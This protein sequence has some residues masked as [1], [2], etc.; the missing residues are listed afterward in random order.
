VFPVTEA[1]A[2]EFRKANKGLKATVGV[3]GT[4]G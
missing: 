3:S 4:G 1:V 2:E